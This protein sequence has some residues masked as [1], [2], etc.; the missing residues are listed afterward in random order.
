V[1]HASHVQVEDEL[2]VHKFI[3]GTSTGGRQ[4][5]CEQHIKGSGTDVACELLIKASHL[6]IYDFFRDIADSIPPTWL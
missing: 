2:G 4:R 5:D 3:D 1:S 6:G